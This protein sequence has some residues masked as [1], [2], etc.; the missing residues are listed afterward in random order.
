MTWLVWSPQCDLVSLL[1]WSVVSVSVFS[2]EHRPGTAGW[3]TA[4]PV[5]AAT[6]PLAP[7]YGTPA[8]GTRAWRWWHHFSGPTRGHCFP[9]NGEGEALL[10]R[11]R[12]KLVS[13]CCRYWL[14][15]IWAC[16]G[17]HVYVCVCV[18]VC[19]CVLASL[20]VSMFLCMCAYRM[21]WGSVCELG[22]SPWLQ[23]FPPNPRGQSQENV[24]QLTRHVP[25]FW[26]GLDLQKGSLALQPIRTIETGLLLWQHCYTSLTHT[27][28]VIPLCARVWLSKKERQRAL[29]GKGEK[30]KESHRWPHT[31]EGAVVGNVASQIQ[32]SVIDV[33]ILHA[34]DELSSHKAKALRQIW[35]PSQK[36]GPGEIKRPERD[37]E[38]ER[39]R[40]RDCNCFLKIYICLLSISIY[41]L[42]HHRPISNVLK[43]L[44]A[45][46]LMLIHFY[47]IFTTFLKTFFI[48]II[49]H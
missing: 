38:R 49:S 5:P 16:V 9:E 24:S 30:Q 34:A 41:S 4:L 46:V 35:H 11:E 36:E 19:V 39:G 40:Q 37:T 15:N 25:P 2:R 45:N 13:W 23:S 33:Q 44:S 27:M 32:G 48:S 22:D 14:N 7:V 6:P 18:C 29:K 12:E 31:R 42:Q 1:L 26:Q 43:A 47:H 21:S 28:N 8:P 3:C 10:E 20:C 17:L